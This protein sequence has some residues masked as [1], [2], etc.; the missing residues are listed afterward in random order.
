MGEITLVRC[1]SLPSSYQCTGVYKYYYIF[2]REVASGPDCEVWQACTAP[3][4]ATFSSHVTHIK[5]L[6]SDT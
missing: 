6:Y 3:R 1:F 5:R 2:F 4:V